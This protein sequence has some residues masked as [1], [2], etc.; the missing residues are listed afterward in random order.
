GLQILWEQASA[1]SIEEWAKISDIK[2]SDIVALAREFTNHGK[3]AAADIHRG[4]SQHTNGFY[5]VFAWFTLNLLIGNYDWQGGMSQAATY[6]AGGGKTFEGKLPDGSE[7]KWAQPYPIGKFTSAKT[8]P[9]GIDV[10][11]ANAKYE[12][13]TIFK[14]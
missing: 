2:A 10:I 11:R 1:K 7:A 4:A 13:T 8:T 9:F 3:R 5:N 14:D 6:D 12:D